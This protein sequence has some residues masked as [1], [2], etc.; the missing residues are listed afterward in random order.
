MEKKDSVIIT[1]QDERKGSLTG[2]NHE[3]L[4]HLA[5][6][7]RRGSVASIETARLEEIDARNGQFHR[8]FTPRQVHVSVY[9]TKW[10]FE[11]HCG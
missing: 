6:A 11:T 4:S 5:G 7:D 9:T 1:T 8:S 2:G 3:K 10:L